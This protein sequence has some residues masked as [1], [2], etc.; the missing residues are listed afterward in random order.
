MHRILITFLGTTDYS[1]TVY[2]WP[3]VGEH[4]TPYVAAALAKLWKA[5]HVIVLATQAAEDKNA[6]PLRENLLAAGCPEPVLSRLPAGRTEDELW[7]QFRVIREAVESAASGDVLMD[8]THGFR[9]QSFFAGAILGVLRGAGVKPHQI[10]LVYG[11]YRTEELISPIWDLTL[12]I[13][14]MDWAQALRLFQATG[15]AEPVVELARR[16]EQRETARTLASKSRDFPRLGQLA[17]AIRG[18]ALDLATVRV[19]AI[20]TGYKQS[21]SKKPNARGSAARL[22][23]AID[24]SREHVKVKLP[25]LALI[26][27]QL[28][29]RVIPLAA[30]RLHGPAGQRAQHALARY[31]LMLSR[32]PEAAAVVRE[33]CVSLHAADECGVEVNSPDYQ[34]QQRLEAECQFGREDPDSLKE[35]GEIRNDIEHAGFRKQPLSA[36]T[37]QNRIEKLVQRFA[38]LGKEEAETTEEDSLAPVPSRTFF[39]TRHSGAIQWAAQ[40]GL[41]IDATA[42]HLDP[43]E[44]GPGDIVIGTLPVHLAAEVCQR[45]ARYLHLVLELPTEW[46]GRELTV[47]DMERFGA[48]LVEYQV[49]RIPA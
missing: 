28:A 47:E 7:A 31:Y 5:D 1:E 10:E 35:I 45:G 20:I 33:A 18:F 6:N 49:E 11:E 17:E 21:D 3:Y 22:L 48:R 23:A 4:R 44:V 29:E 26:L 46:R 32:Y 25:P 16:M 43:A 40:K 19:A 38:P 37:L 2:Q 12:F 15:V 27:D 13:E 39:V 36:K 34:Q 42:T 30:D 24:R 8:I 14:L 9:S 41:T